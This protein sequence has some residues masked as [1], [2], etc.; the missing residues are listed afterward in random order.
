MGNVHTNR[1]RVALPVHADLVYIGY[2]YGYE[3][4]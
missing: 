4:G 2:R 3:C 1:A